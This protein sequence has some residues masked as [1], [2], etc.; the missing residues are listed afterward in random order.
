M[1]ISHPG[2]ALAALALAAACALPPATALGQVFEAREANVQRRVN[3]VLSLMGFMLTPDVT[4]GSLAFSNE[5]AGNPDFSMTS[6]GGGFTTSRS[7]PLYLEGTAGFSRYDPTF[8]ASNGTEE[9]LVPAKW[10]V[11]SVTTGVG[12]DFPVAPDLVLRPIAN[13]T[14]GHVESDASL[15]GRFIEAQTGKT[16]EFLDGGRLDAYGLG[17]SL[18]LDYEYYRPWYEIDVELRYTNIHLKSFGG[19]SEAA[20][21]SADAQTINLWTRYRAPT[22][23][24]M[25]DRPLRYVLEYVYTRFLGDLDGVLGFSHLNSVGAGLELDLSKYDTIVSRARLVGRYKFGDNVTG[26]SVGFAVSF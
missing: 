12:W 17:G 22:G 5:A 1:T 19:T 21:G 24:V 8:V 2:N 7:V 18:M 9:R 10:N 15:G 20:Q 25:L 13:F 4:T 6:L 11:F 16:L 23:M 14:Y 26:W 3:A